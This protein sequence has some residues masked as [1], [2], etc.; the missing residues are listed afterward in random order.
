[1]RAL[2]KRGHLIHGMTYP[3]STGGFAAVA[4]VMLNAGG[5][6]FRGAAEP[7]EGQAAAW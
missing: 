3:G 6:V 1:V 5:K 7:P 4:A 2:E